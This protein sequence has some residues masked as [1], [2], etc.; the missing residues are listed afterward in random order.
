MLTAAGTIV[1]T[2]AYMSPEQACG[3]ELDTRTDIWSFGCVLYE[4]LTG[5]RVF[6]G[7]T[8]TEILAAVLE[9]EPD[10]AA[11]PA[12]IPDSLQSLLWRCLRKDAARRLRDIGDARI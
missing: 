12:A 4:M 11:L 10:W 7:S 2:A 3:K 9:R 1:G 6:G 8:V 5:R